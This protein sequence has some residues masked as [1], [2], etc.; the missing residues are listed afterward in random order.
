[1]DADI[2]AVG[3]QGGASFDG[4]TFTV[5]GSGADIWN[6]ADAF[7]YV[8]QPLAGD[9]QLVARVVAVQD[10]NSW[11]K[12]G[13]M[14]RSTLDANATFA[15]ML[16]SA[17]KGAAFQYRVKAGG[18]AAGTAV[19]GPAAP[20]WI[21]IV[22]A[23]VTLTGYESVDGATWVQ[24]GSVSIA[25]APSVL[26]G[27]A[28]TSHDITQTATAPFD[29]VSVTVAAPS[30]PPAPLPSPWLDT[31]IGAVG[32]VGGASFDGTTFTVSGAGADIWN[33]ADAF[34]YAYQPLVGDGQL[35]ARV[36]SVQN[37]Y[38]WSKAGVMIR[39]TLDADSAF[40][41]MLVSAAKGTAF[42]YRAST[43][44]AAAGPT[45]SGPTAPYWIK[46]VRAGSTLTGYQ[47]ADGI[48]W[49]Q[50]GSVSVPMAQ[51]VYIGLAV[52]SHD[53]TQ[54]ATAT[55]DHVQ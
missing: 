31:D 28:V 33:T 37:V 49:V 52:T 1:M 13:V 8:Y 19:T 47:S 46:I 35:V 32:R 34:H 2:G 51:S 38:S 4:T 48:T 15:Q 45:V 17:A 40:A 26:V 5:T 11:S 9:G 42:Q 50:V 3:P 29:H 30:A 23:G 14:I 24:V 6:S 22:R 10:V 16:I 55:F 20:Y 27:L 21:K 12:A 44:G 7:H 25:M 54:T 43:G 36:T 18:S 53:N 39:E 41:Q